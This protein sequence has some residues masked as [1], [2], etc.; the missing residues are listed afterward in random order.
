M[1]M[2]IL[3]GVPQNLHT[4]RQHKATT[5]RFKPPTPEAIIPLQQRPAMNQHSNRT[6]LWGLIIYSAQ[7]S[8]FSGKNLLSMP[9]SPGYSHN[10]LSTYLK[11]YSTLLF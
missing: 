8:G 1:D 10:T 3:R 7:R 9:R 2:F 11:K 6:T 5:Q 4:L